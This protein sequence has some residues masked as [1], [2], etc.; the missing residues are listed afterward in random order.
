M[1]APCT[2][3]AMVTTQRAPTWCNHR[4]GNCKGLAITVAV[5]HHPTKSQFHGQHDHRDGARGDQ[6]YPAWH[7]PHQLRRRSRREIC[8]VLVTDITPFPDRQEIGIQTGKPHRPVP[9]GLILEEA[10]PLVCSTSLRCLTFLPQRETTRM[11][12]AIH[13]TPRRTFNRDGGADRGLD[14]GE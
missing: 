5:I 4:C 12:Y 8:D 14:R 10:C 9:M 2:G 1:I 7:P 6:P 3:T 11:A 13:I